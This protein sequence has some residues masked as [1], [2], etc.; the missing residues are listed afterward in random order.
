[1]ENSDLLSNDLQVSHPVQ[2]YLL[3]TAKWAKFLS[4]LGFIGCGV[5]IIFAF[6]APAFMSTTP[7]Y[8]DMNGRALSAAKGTIT[9]TYIISG[10]LLFF[11]CLYLYR[12]SS[13]TQ[14]SIKAINQENFEQSFM[15][16][17][18]AF[19]FYGIMCI[20]ILSLIVLVM[21]FAAIFAAVGQ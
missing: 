20:V 5:M 17:K 3:E 14:A 10:V 6:I 19:K 8:S 21:I 2:S 15:N 1:M 7:P 18:S 11:P 4:I 16:L 9:I 13:H 12:F